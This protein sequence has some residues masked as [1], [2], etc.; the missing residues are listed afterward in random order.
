MAPDS[1][2]RF[3]LFRSPQFAEY[4]SRLSIILEKEWEL[5][6]DRKVYLCKLPAPGFHHS[7]LTY[8][9]SL[10]LTEAIQRFKE[11]IQKPLNLPK[12]KGYCRKKI[13]NNGAGTPYFQVYLAPEDKRCKTKIGIRSLKK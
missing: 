9:T 10:P 12:L 11:K 6:S 2:A 7:E 5:T 3:T 13:S 4:L 1:N 8:I